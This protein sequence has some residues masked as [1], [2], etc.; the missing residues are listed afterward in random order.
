MASTAFPRPPPPPPYQPPSW[1]YLEVSERLESVSHMGYTYRKEPNL[2]KLGREGWELVVIESRGSAKTR[3][4]IF[5]RQKK[6]S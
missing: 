6:E 1:E 3:V 2:V 5:K 4:W